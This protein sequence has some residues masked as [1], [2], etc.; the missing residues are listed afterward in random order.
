MVI[1]LLAKL[2]SLHMAGIQSLNYDKTSANYSDTFAYFRIKNN[3]F[4][5]CFNPRDA[6]RYFSR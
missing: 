1:T 2:R 5:A 4:G 3:T 6:V